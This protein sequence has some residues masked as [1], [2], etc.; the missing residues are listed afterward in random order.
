M[1]VKDFSAL[2]FLKT[3]NN[4]KQFQDVKSILKH[5]TRMVNPELSIMILAYKRTD[6]IQEAIMSALNQITEH[7]YEVVVV[8]NS[9]EDNAVYGVVSNIDDPRLSYYKNERNI[10]TTGNMNRC[11]EL[12]E[13]EY[14]TVLCDDDVLLPNFV[15]E[16]LNKISLV[17]GCAAVGSKFDY[18]DENGNIIAEGYN[19]GE[20]YHAKSVF[21][22]LLGYQ[23]VLVG[24][25][26]SKKH[27]IELGG[28]DPR[29]T[30]GP[31]AVF[32][33]RLNI[34]HR[35]YIYNKV[36]S[37][38]RVWG[39][40]GSAIPEVGYD[41]AAFIKWFTGSLGKILHLDAYFIELNTRYL[42]MNY[43]VASTESFKAGCDW[44]QYNEIIGIK[45][46]TEI[47]KDI[48]NQ[49]RMIYLQR[50]AV[51][52]GG[53]ICF[54]GDMALKVCGKDSF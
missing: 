14:F 18:I 15:E 47:E 44:K 46:L 34:K 13:G 53:E 9:E 5:G 25:V 36:L 52:P 30:P 17:P 26:F 37:W 29:T 40:M 50:E 43:E 49:M 19:R 51:G 22:W 35:C 24:S 54:V 38:Y 33:L 23:F 3:R 4:F 7:R 16:M 39:K 48:Y 8:D 21:K 28:L 1:K 2:D 32:C 41:A 10:T 42:V 12:A 20:F 45:P 27:F 31:D 11:A 6:F